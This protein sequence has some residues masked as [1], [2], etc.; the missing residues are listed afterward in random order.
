MVLI[1]SDFPPSAV[2]PFFLTKNRCVD[3]LFLLQELHTNLPK[4]TS[5]FFKFNFIDA[6]YQVLTGT[7]YKLLAQFL[8]INLSLLQTGNYV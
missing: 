3:F 7:A 6:L 4:E 1:T 2:H 5:A 8:L